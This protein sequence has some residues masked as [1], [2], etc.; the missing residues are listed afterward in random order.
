ML[1]ERFD[2]IKES[3]VRDEEQ[4]PVGTQ[5]REEVVDEDN[6]VLTLT[7]DLGG[8]NDTLNVRDGDAPRDLALEFCEKN[9]LADGVVDVLA[10]YIASQMAEQLDEEEDEEEEEEEPSRYSP[11]TTQT[12]TQTQTQFDL[13]EIQNDV[14]RISD[15]I[16][17]S[18]TTTKPSVY[19]RLY[20]PPQDHST[21]TQS[22][23]NKENNNNNMA[24]NGHRLYENAKRVREKR[25]HQIEKR[26][27][28]RLEEEM[29]VSIR[30]ENQQEKGYCPPRPVFDRLSSQDNFTGVYGK[31]FRSGDGRLNAESDLAVSGL[32]R[33]T[34]S[35][36]HHSE[37]GVVATGS[38]W[39][40]STL[41]SF[42]LRASQRT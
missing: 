33:K 22:I 40:A 31:R 6:V 12:L 24:F 25:K 16:L 7:V 10:D 36:D 9:G 34:S 38:S 26:E 15:T 18:T 42:F 17:P 30:T 11:P 20:K 29:Q 23:E 37:R 3:F 8:C 4:S 13:K 28:E 39:T 1:L 41:G 5:K 32:S 27:R 19:E 14:N 2:R 35:D 21:T